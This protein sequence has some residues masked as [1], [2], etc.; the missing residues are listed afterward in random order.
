[1]KIKNL[2]TAALL[3]GGVILAVPTVFGQTYGSVYASYPNDLIMG[4]QNQAGNG[5]EDYI[6]NLGQAANI[7]GQSTVVDL[8]TDFSLTD[9]NAVLRTSSSMFGGV[10]GAANNDNSGTPNTADVFVTQLRVGGAGNP[11]V[12]GSTVT[13]QL[14]RSQDNTTFSAISGGLVTPAAGSGTL[15]TS[16][17]WESYVEP[18]ALNS[19]QQGAFESQAALDPDSS[20]GASSVLYEDLWES[21]SSSLTGAKPFTYLGYFTLDLTGANPKL[22][23]TS[24]NVPASLSAP[25]VVSVSKNGN[26]VTVVSSNALASHSYQLQYTTSL[27]SPITWI[28]AGS[29]VTATSTTVTNTDSTATD[30]H[31]FY[32]IE[33]Q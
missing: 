2:T 18:G 21:S 9:F 23:F 20:V 1:M 19:G 26:I 5:T 17:S 27:N 14:S 11:A 3:V 12:A 31:R 13:Q 24:I 6:I 22:T 7:V 10:I 25:S 4:F 32:R 8:S 16:K 30:A 33:A 28:P 15:D 29:P